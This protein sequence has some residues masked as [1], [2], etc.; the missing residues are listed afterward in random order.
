MTS[1]TFEYDDFDGNHRVETCYFNLTKAE[2]IEWL[3]MNGDY[4]L[5]KLILKLNEKS[6]GKEVMAIF[7]DLICR[8]YG[9]KSLDGRRFVKTD[10]VKANFMETEAFSILFTELVTD[11]EKAAQFVKDILPHDFMNEI[12]KIMEQ[13]PDGIPDAAKDYLIRK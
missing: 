1:R 10:D 8:S 7:K 5:D 12:Q 13:N 11:G 3:T 2:T 6:N 4:T 9:E